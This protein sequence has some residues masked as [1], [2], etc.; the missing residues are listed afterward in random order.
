MS[1]I[2]QQ[3]FFEQIEL[4]L[5]ID[6]R[7]VQAALLQ[8]EALNETDKKNAHLK[9]KAAMDVL[10][11][12]EKE[13]KMAER[14][15]FIDWYRPTWIRKKMSPYNIHR[16]YILINQLLQNIDAAKK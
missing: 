16:S 2:K 14:P 11:T 8:L 9:V 12:F 13:I 10:I 15:P 3:Y 7:P 1:P 5:L 4:P 6:Y